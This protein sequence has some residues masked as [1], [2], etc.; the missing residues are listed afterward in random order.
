MWVMGKFNGVPFTAIGN[1]ELGEAIPDDRKIWC[2]HCGKRHKIKEA[3][4]TR[5]DG[6]PCDKPSGAWFYK[7]GESTYLAAI[8]NRM[9]D[10]WTS[11]Q[12]SKT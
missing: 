10:K 9:I 11:K 1:D 2:P 12:E 6:E 8:Q 5:I 3:R 4:A 7:C